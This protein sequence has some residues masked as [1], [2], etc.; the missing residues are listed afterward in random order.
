M[1]SVVLGRH[2]TEAFRTEI[3]AASIRRAFA[4]LLLA[5]LLL[6]TAV[7]LL[8]VNDSEQGLFRLAFEAFSAFATVG[9]SLGVTPEL[10]FLGKLIIMGAMFTGRV[11]ALT[12]LG[13]VVARS[14]AQPYRYPS[15]E[16]MF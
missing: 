14:G 2:R 10:S 11:G 5:T 3:S 12:L 6:G 8:A 13:A 4:I 16:I 7:L 1:K 9:L 15:E